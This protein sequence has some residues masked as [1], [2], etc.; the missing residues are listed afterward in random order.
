MLAF[1]SFGLNIRCASLFSLGAHGSPEPG[2]S[3]AAANVP[4]SSPYDR[5]PKNRGPHSTGKPVV[6][7]D[8]VADRRKC[9]TAG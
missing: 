5:Q 4:A 7:C 3:N 6:A 2:M 9:V 1:A 8:I